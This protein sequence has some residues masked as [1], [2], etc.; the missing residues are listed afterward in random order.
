MNLKTV[1]FLFYGILTSTNSVIT[2]IEA[3]TLAKTGFHCSETL[4]LY[5]LISFFFLLRFFIAFIYVLPICVYVHV[6]QT[7][8]IPAGV[9]RR[10]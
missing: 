6:Q 4:F 2:F 1:V 10:Y 5:N 8:M 3:V 7:F 9:K